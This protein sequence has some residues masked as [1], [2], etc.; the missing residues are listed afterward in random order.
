MRVL[1]TGTSYPRGP[2][3]WRG[4]FIHDMAAALAR[5]EDLTL[6]LWAPP[7]ELP[8]GVTSALGEGDGSW[9]EGLLHRG[10]IA[11]LLRTH[12][13]AGAAAGVGLLRRLGRAYRASPADV[14]HVNWLQNALPLPP[15]RPALVTVLGSDYKLLALPG[16]AGALRRVLRRNPCILAP[17]AAWM[18]EGLTA[19]FGDVA[20]VCPIPFGVEGHWFEV[21]RRPHG[22][23]RW[24]AVTRLTR[25]KLG[26]LLA[27][28]EGLFGTGRELHLFGPMQESLT[29]PPW[30]TWHGP[31][32]PAELRDDWFPGATGLITLSRHAE[33]RPQVVL[34]AMAAGLPVLAS[35]IPAHRDVLRHGETGWLAASRADLAA[36]LEWLEA[37][38]RGGALGAAARAW[39]KR[40]VGAWDGCAA[41]YAAAYR[42]LLEG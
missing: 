40:E 3:D 1:L 8:P 15:R 17:N 26:E 30:V 34:E 37:D 9:L 13:L 38:G 20:E 22:V 19:R 6:D 7:G 16:M 27:W 32:H 10:G 12:P 21:E 33:G 5:R 11:H 25:G 31:T 14:L 29:L 24:L 18:A 41:R 39:V 35:D 42:A 4:R 28:G 2:R 23:P 36:G